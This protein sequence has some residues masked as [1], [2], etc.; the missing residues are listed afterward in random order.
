M[1]WSSSINT[2]GEQSEPQMLGRASSNLFGGFLGINGSL[3]A[4]G[5]QD[6]D[7]YRSGQYGGRLCSQAAK[8]TGVLLL[9]AEKTLDLL[10]NFTLRQLD[11]VLGGTVIRHEGQEAIVGDVELLQ[12]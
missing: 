9:G 8:L 2:S 4:H 11:I 12:C 7:I 6:N 3:F 1:G 10:T 5:S